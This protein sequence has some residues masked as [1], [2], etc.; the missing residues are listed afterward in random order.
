L[1]ELRIVPYASTLNP[2]GQ[3]LTAPE[4]IAAPLLTD[5]LNT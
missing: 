1:G 3:S 2:T 4:L 5:E